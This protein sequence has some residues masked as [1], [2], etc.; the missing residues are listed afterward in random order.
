MSSPKIL[1]QETVGNRTLTIELS[2]TITGFNIWEFPRARLHAQIHDKEKVKARAQ[3]IIR[4][5]RNA[6]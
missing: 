4:E 2:Q 6:A 3:E 5:W 1:W